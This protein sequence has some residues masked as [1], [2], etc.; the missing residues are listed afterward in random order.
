M[1]F[2]NKQL[3]SIGHERVFENI[4]HVFRGL[5]VTGNISPICIFVPLWPLCGS[6]T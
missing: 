3:K 6:V 1:W 2:L 4:G 5:T